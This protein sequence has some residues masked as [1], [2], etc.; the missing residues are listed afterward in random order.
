[1]TSL[2]FEAII[3][4]VLS[5]SFEGNSS[6]EKKDEYPDRQSKKKGPARRVPKAKRQAQTKIKK[7]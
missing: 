3:N 5:P 2:E 6:A 4:N 1:L 7:L